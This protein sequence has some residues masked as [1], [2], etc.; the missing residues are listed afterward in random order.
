MDDRTA[1]EIL[2]IRP[3]TSLAIVEKRYEHFVKLYRKY[4]MGEPLEYSTNDLLQM[5]EAYQCLLYKRIEDKELKDL[6]PQENQGLCHQALRYGVKLMAPFVKRHRAK[7]IYTCVMLVLTFLIIQIMQYQPVD[8]KIAVLSDPAGSI[9]EYQ[10][11]RELMDAYEAEIMDNVVT[12]RRPVVEY[13]SVYSPEGTSYGVSDFT[14]SRDV[15]VYVMEE[16]LLIR[17]KSL[18]FEFVELKGLDVQPVYDPVR[19]QV[20][21]RTQLHVE[22]TTSLYRY[23]CNYQNDNQSWVAVLSP[24]CRHRAQAMQFLRYL[25]EGTAP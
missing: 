11:R 3:G 15:D 7:I 9:F 19:Q 14:L 17:L 10:I 8:L 5:K 22:L 12:I 2:K 4:L 21:V 13:Q 23:I 25:N 6:Y 20:N 24:D 18:G 16:P 1:Y